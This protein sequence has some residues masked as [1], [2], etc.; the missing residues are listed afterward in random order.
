M[1]HVLS[2][3]PCFWKAYYVKRSINYSEFEQNWSSQACVESLL[4]QSHL[5]TETKSSQICKKTT[6]LILIPTDIL[7]TPSLAEFF[8]S[9]PSGAGPWRPGH[10]ARPVHGRFGARAHPRVGWGG[11]AEPH[12]RLLVRCPG[13]GAQ[14]KHGPKG[15]KLDAVDVISIYIYIHSMCIYIY[16][17]V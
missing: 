8:V 7:S 15:L 2:S 3:S 16:I 13:W 17:Y 9:H 5:S 10:V 6:F 14:K 12:Q 11:A 1:P 4:T